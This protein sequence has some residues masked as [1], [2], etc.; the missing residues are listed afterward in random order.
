MS[1][2]KGYFSVSSRLNF[3]IKLEILV[4]NLDLV[5]TTWGFTNRSFEDVKLFTDGLH[6]EKCVVL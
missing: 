1:N 2:G 4:V 5:M 3:A 6:D